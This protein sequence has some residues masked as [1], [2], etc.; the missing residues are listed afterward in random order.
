MIATALLASDLQGSCVPSSSTVVRT[1]RLTSEEVKRNEQI[2]KHFHLVG[3]V[4][5]KLRSKLPPHVNA[6]DLHGAGVM[7]LVAAAERFVPSQASTFEAYARLRIRGAMLDELRKLDPCSRRSRIRGKKIQL[8]IQEIA[9]ELG[10]TPTDEEVSARLRISTAELGQWRHAI[11]SVRIVSLD[12]PVEA[13]EAAS[14]SLHEVVPDDNQEGVREM[15]EKRDLMNR[16]TECVAALPEL[17]KKVLAMYYFEKM[18]FAEI[19]AAFHLTESRICQIH[20]QAVLKLRT[21]VRSERV[22]A[23]VQRA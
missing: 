1:N 2:E 12:I 16:L 8:A 9:Q 22:D 11:E 3:K 19:A 4:L 20:R 18:R 10:R 15:M 6:D 23:R 21:R 17:E 5:A 14:R 7:G 13:G